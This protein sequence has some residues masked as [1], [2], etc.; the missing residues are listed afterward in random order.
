M[1]KVVRKSLKLGAIFVIVLLALLLLALVFVAFKGGSIAKS[2]LEEHD[3]ELVGRELFVRNIDIS[4]LGS[5]VTVDSVVVKEQN[6]RDDFLKF[7]TLFVDINLFDLL[8]NEVNLE[9]IHLVGADVPV[10][11]RDSVFN[12]SDIIE[13]FSKTDS[14]QTSVDDEAPSSNWGV[15]LYD[16]QLR[17]CNALYKDLSLKSKFDLHDI[18]IFIPGVYFSEKST[19]VGLNLNFP[20]GGK[21]H[22]QMKYD[23]ASSGFQIDAQITGF[24]IDCI[25]P[26]MRQGVRVGKVQGL[27]DTKATMKGDFNHI[28]NFTLSGN[29]TLRNVLV[30]DDKGRLILS[31][32]QTSAELVRLNLSDNEIHLGLI[33]G[34]GIASQFLIDKDGLDNISYFSSSP[35]AAARKER[36][37]SIAETLP[38][39]VKTIREGSGKPLIFKIDKVDMR[40][41]SMHMVDESLPETFNYDVT[42]FCVKAENIT[43]DKANDVAVSGRLGRT[44]TMSARWRGSL[45]DLS[46]QNIMATLTNVDLTEFTPYF[47]PIFAYRI[48]G[49]NMSVVSQNVIVDNNLRGTNQLSVMNCTVEKDKSVE[50]PEFNVPLK[51]ALYVVKDKNGKIGI[52][53][54]VSGNVN[55]PEFSYKKIIVKTLMNFL[56]KVGESPFKSMA[57]VFGSSDNADEM[58][59]DPTSATLGVETYDQLNKVIDML[60]QKPDLKANLVQN[61]NY[62]VAV[63]DMS[64]LQLKTAFFLKQHPDKTAETL[65]IID[66][67]D[68]AK[69]SEKDTAF[70]AY[71]AL[72]ST[73]GDT[74]PA[75]VAANLYAAAARQELAALAEKRSALIREYLNQQLGGQAANIDILVPGDDSEKK[76]VGK[77]LLK[78]DLV[79]E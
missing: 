47:N 44:G 38:D 50:N 5:S 77:T 14:T 55:S 4:L 57:K 41:M 42:D 54:P 60:K 48:T 68:I 40:G 23:I 58:T 64:L 65:E 24:N 10:L 75:K 49:G 45:N 52:D 21:L 22:A 53:L 36:R 71:V 26:Y 13:H 69:L 56:V 67:D 32:N 59:F 78:L 28:M 17:H 33:D 61:I 73:N 46:N 11:Q 34:E 37:D 12:F 30:T 15:G 2:Y 20:N 72:V 43:L 70:M 63:A 74:K 25:E 35:E 62:E 9:H 31:A 29:S 76:Y 1:N 19:D 39:S 27:L 3:Q 16:I 8:S 79:T 66:R 7:D 18:N 51:T 6:K